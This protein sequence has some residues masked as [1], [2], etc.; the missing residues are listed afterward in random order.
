MNE[1]N[2]NR[3]VSGR[4]VRQGMLVSMLG[5][6]L[7]TQSLYSAP[8]GEGSPAPASSPADEGTGKPASTPSDDVGSNPA[9]TAT[10]TP[11]PPPTPTPAPSPSRPP[12]LD[13]GIP[14]LEE[15][16]GHP[17]N[18]DMPEDMQPP[19]PVP[20]RA[21]DTMNPEPP[22][23]S[24]PLLNPYSQWDLSGIE[25]PLFGTE[26]I[27]E[28]SE[29]PLSLAGN[30]HVTPHF[31]LSTLYDSNI[32]LQSSGAESDFVTVIS[33]GI[34]VRLG[35]KES[36]FYL[37]GDYTLDAILFA[38]H[39]SENA[40]NQ[41]ARLDLQWSLPKTIFGLHVGVFADTG[42][43]IDVSDRV[44]RQVYYVGLTS[45]YVL[46]DKTS[47]DLNADWN[48][49]HYHGL[50]SSS[51][52]QVQA[53][54][55]YEF[56]P[57]VTVGVGSA[58]GYVNV[59]GGG[60]QVFEQGSVRVSFRTTEKL[61]L[62]ADTGVD[63]R[64]FSQ[65]GGNAV[66]PVFG[67]KAAWAVREGT[68]IDLSCRRQIYASAIFQDQNYTATSV[69]LSVRQRFTDNVDL[70]LS[71]G[72]V[73]ASYSSTAGGIPASREDNYFYLRPALQWHVLRWLSIGIF[74]EYSQNI[75]SGQ[76]ARS[77]TR[78]RAGIQASVAF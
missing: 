41:N 27:T 23:N 62:I 8:P 21:E 78:D 42:T 24:P 76:G 70:F 51:Q 11:A 48:F 66:N 5:G 64:Q 17:K 39:G 58:V 40:I 31:S 71:G 57:K 67:V 69:D 16:Y 54:F 15:N 56:S 74:Y 3:V 18:S 33:P 37:I 38:Q 68:E 73:N 9:G 52:E 19:L 44:Q 77:F 34:T 60:N 7:L 4:W 72:Y 12:Q 13:P 10:S 45:H 6:F 50:I 53:Y 36:M 35:N 47:W 49:T 63:V 32:N 59:Q 65:G 1:L 2:M 29:R 28:F 14:G 30:S 20:D 46:T 61:T 43:S 26:E 55:N 75:S 22:I 25:S